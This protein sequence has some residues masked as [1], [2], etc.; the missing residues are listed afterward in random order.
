MQTELEEGFPCGSA[1]KE[2]ACNAVDLGSIPVLGRS[3]GEERLPTLVF[4]LKEFHEL[5]SLWGHKESDT[6]E[7]LSLSL[8]TRESET[9]AC[10]TNPGPSLSI[11][12]Y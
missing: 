8:Q 10:R 11:K 2:S 5:Y 6:P 4:R 3:L 7:R 9:M 1:G 12:F